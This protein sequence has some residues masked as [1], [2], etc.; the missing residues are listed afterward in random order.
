MEV[1]KFQIATK[2]PACIAPLDCRRFP[3]AGG[4]RRICNV[5]VFIEKVAGSFWS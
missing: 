5:E 2:S 3:S 4:H 1:A